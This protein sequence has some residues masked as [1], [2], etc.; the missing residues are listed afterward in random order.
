MEGEALDPALPSGDIQ[1]N[2]DEF[3]YPDDREPVLSRVS[4]SIKKGSTLGIAGKTGSGKTTL[5]KLLIREFEGK[6]AQIIFGE[7]PIA[8]YKIE[9][10]R[11]VIGYVPQDHF[12]FSAT[13]AENIGFAKYDAPIDEIMNA[14]KACQ[15]P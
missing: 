10:I 11:A 6:K 2:I 8:H 3:S 15:Y 9:N 12:L 1:F 5:L 7:K 4:F 14:A 13:I